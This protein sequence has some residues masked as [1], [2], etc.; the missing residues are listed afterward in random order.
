M[1]RR[2]VMEKLFKSF[3]VVTVIIV[4]LCGSAL[5]EQTEPAAQ[6]EKDWYVALRFGFQPYTV[7]MDG[8]VG[9]RN[10]NYQTDL[11][12][13]LDNTDTTILGGEMEFGKGKLFMILSGFY[14][15]TEA[16]DGRFEESTFTEMSFNPM[17]GYR[18][19]QGDG[20]TPVSVDLMA[21]AYYVKISTEVSFDKVKIRDEKDTDFTDAMVGARAYYGFTKQFGVGCFGEIGAGGSELQYVVSANLVYN[22]TNWFA[23]SVG[24]KYWYFKYDDEENVIRDF[25]QQLYGPTLGVQFRF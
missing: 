15:N 5:A 17:I 19:Y 25:E 24:Y 3:L 6:A 21:G 11:A 7:E 20:P 14:Q 2:R 1:K 9:D 23:M 12:D 22:F 18:V 8:K 4:S 13:I 16:N 10:F